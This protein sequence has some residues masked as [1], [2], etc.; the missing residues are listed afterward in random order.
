MVTPGCYTPLLCGPKLKVLIGVR[1]F[2]SLGRGA[3][4]FPPWDAESSRYSYDMGAGVGTAIDRMVLWNRGAG[5]ACR[6]FVP[7]P[8]CNM[9]NAAQ[10]TGTPL[11][12][13]FGFYVGLTDQPLTAD[14][15]TAPS[16]TP[17]RNP[18][19]R[20]CV[21]GGGKIVNPN[22][23]NVYELDCRWVG[24]WAGAVTVTVL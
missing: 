15:I 6:L 17:C 21:C 11:E 22:I 16:T 7:Q 13:D 19:D 2:G 4:F 23:T 24:G 18:G 1:A 20:N 10:R 8:L 5:H 9:A 12:Q 14:T 3:V